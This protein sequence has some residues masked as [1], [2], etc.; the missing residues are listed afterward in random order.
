V[1]GLAIIARITGVSGV[2]ASEPG[3][4]GYR[5]ST[6]PSLRT[7]NAEKFSSPETVLKKSL[8]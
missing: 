5:I 8:K 3:K 1:S 4:I 6:E 2:N 7:S